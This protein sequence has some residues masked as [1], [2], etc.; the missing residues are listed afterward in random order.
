MLII[1]KKYEF[2]IKKI[3]FI[4]F[5][6]KLKKTTNRPKKSQVYCKLKGFKDSYRS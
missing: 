5:I 6:I 4:K 1:I 3:E 2:F